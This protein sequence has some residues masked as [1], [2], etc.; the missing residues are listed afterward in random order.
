M[1]RATKPMP[2]AS[3][4]NIKGKALDARIH[5]GA[6]QPQ[7]AQQRHAHGLQQRPEASTTAPTRPSTI[8]AKYSA[9]PK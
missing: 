4:G 6:H 9:G 3:S 7:Q 2:S 8:R 5:I 1:A